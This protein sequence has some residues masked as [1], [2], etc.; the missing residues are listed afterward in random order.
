MTDWHEL[1]RRVVVRTTVRGTSLRQVFFSVRGKAEVAQRACVGERKS[2]RRGRRCL[3]ETKAAIW[4]ASR[5]VAE[6]RPPL[7]L[8]PLVDDAAG[9]AL[10]ALDAAG[11]GD[12]DSGRHANRAL[13]VV[14]ELGGRGLA[15]VGLSCRGHRLHQHL[16]RIEAIL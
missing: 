8:R 1:P 5:A 10:A 4:T 11:I 9:L 15:R 6:A 13:D 3:P 14:A 7:R 16:H 12:G 2:A